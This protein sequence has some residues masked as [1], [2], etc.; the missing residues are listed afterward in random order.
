MMRSLLAALQL[1]APAGAQTLGKYET[2]AGRGSGAMVLGISSLDEHSIANGQGPGLVLDGCTYSCAG[3][4]QWNGTGYSGATSQIVL[5]NANGQLHLTYGTPVNSM[6]VDLMAYDGYGDTV[7]VTVYNS[8]MV[9]IH[10]SPPILIP[11]SAPV[12]FSYAAAARA[13]ARCS[14]CRSPRWSASS[15]PTAPTPSPRAATCR[16]ASAG[17][18]SR[19]WTSP[20]ARPPASSSCDPADGGR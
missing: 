3:D 1:A 5:S 8:A 12:P 9:P 14:A 13:A 17:D 20:P 18:A 4:L 10:T 6:S 11:N 2:Y 16:P 7:V 19:R 15:T